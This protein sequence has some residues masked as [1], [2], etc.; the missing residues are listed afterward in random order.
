MKKNIIKKNVKFAIFIS[1][2]SLASME[3]VEAYAIYCP[4][5]ADIKFKKNENEKEGVVTYTYY[6]TTGG[7]EH[8]E[9]SSVPTPSLLKQGFVFYGV[10][11]NKQSN[12]FSC[13]YS[14]SNGYFNLKGKLANGCQV[15]PKKTKI[16]T[17]KETYLLCDLKKK[18]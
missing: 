3:A 5:A 13:L 6:G 16:P 17:I 11:K 8:I 10:V 15:I 4:A 18:N 1:L 9:I 2:F 7:E 14:L 12:D